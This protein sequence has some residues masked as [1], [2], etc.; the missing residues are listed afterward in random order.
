[1]SACTN[2]LGTHNNP[3]VTAAEYLETFYK[4]SGAAYV[5]G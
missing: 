4:A 3:T 2:W 5:T 1:M